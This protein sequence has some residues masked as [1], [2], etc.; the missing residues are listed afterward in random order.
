M[1]KLLTSLALALFLTLKV[2]AGTIKTIYNYSRASNDY[3]FYL[4]TF[5]YFGAGT[6]CP[7]ISWFTSQRSNDTLLV[8]AFYDTRGRWATKGCYSYDSIEYVNPFSGINYINVSTNMIANL[9]DESIIDTVRHIDDTTFV[10]SPTIIPD[11]QKNACK[12]YVYPNPAGNTIYV[13]GIDPVSGLHLHLF[14]IMGQ[15]VYEQAGKL[16]QGIA[17]DPLPAGLYFLRLFDQSNN[18]IG[19]TRFCK[20]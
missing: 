14:N 10:L 5:F 18:E 6:S 1:S 17:I 9:T 16:D 8:S 12:L 4:T 3:T 13:K 15:Q 7:K 11:P 19:V 20:R 2:Q